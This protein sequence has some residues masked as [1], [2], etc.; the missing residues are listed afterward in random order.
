MRI[1]YQG[2]GLRH[3]VKDNIVMDVCARFIQRNDLSYYFSDDDGFLTDNK[4]L[5]LRV[6]PD[7]EILGKFKQVAGAIAKFAEHFLPFGE[8]DCPVTFIDMGSQHMQ[9]AEGGTQ[10]MQD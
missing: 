4:A 10:V 9:E 6:G 8:V 3:K 2:D 5:F 1:R 7:D